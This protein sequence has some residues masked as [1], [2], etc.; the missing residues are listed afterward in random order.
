VRDR[1]VESVVGFVLVFS[2]I[3]SSVGVVY[4]FGFEGLQDTRD[5]EQL[6]NVESAFDVLEDNVEDVQREGAPH[7]ATEFKLYQANLQT[8][9]PVEFSINVTNWNA[10]GPAGDGDPST[11]E[12][13]ES[14][15]NAVPI[16]YSPEGSPTTI[17]YVNGAVLRE[18]RG[19]SL[20]LDGPPL[21]LREQGSERTAVFPLVETRE[22]GT[23]A[24]SGSTT[25]LVR[26]DAVLDESLVAATDPAGDTVDGD[27][28]YSVTLN[29]STDP[30]MAPVWADY[31]NE[32]FD[33][34]YG[35][36]PCTVSGGTV[37]CDNVE[38]ERLFVSATRIDVSIEG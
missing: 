1:A 24:I 26:A 38:V 11:A 30:S 17:R 28:T 32:E 8:G 36:E 35:I 29:I 15:I 21:V 12:P 22:R 13:L 18:G 6:S 31:L 34:A 4:V 33:A 19:G 25:V 20:M 14:S 27:G 23:T 16:V 10:V 3:A 2:L 7:R 5:A 9:E 37:T